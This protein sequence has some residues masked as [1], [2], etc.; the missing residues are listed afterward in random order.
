MPADQIEWTRV[1]LIVIRNGIAGNEC[2]IAESVTGVIAHLGSPP[3][4]VDR[5]VS[6]SHP[7][8]IAMMGL[9]GLEQRTG[10]A[11]PGMEPSEPAFTRLERQV[12][13][14]I[15]VEVHDLVTD[16]HLTVI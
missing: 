15:T 3:T 16:V 11:R 10:T 5:L 7:S 1:C 14:H 9:D 6:R 8:R 2:D 12:C 4:T 13:G